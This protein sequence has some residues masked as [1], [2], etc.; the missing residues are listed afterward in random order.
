M[1]KYFLLFTI[2]CVL[3]VAHFIYSGHGIYGDGNGYWS[4]THALY[5]QH[6]LDFR[7]IYD[8]LKNFTAYNKPVPRLTWNITPTKTGALPNHW[9]IGTGILWLPS[10]V[11][12]NFL[13]N[14]CGAAISPY[15][16][17]WE[18]GPGITGIF[19][20]I[21]GCFF[22]EK[23]I[24]T[25]WSKK[26]ALYATLILLGTTNLM[27]Y[28]SIEPALSH[29]AIFFTNALLVYMWVTHRQYS[30]KIWFVWG[31]LVGLSTII[32]ITG[33]FIVIL[34]LYTLGTQ[35]VSEHHISQ[36]V[37]VSFMLFST[38]LGIAI[39]PQLVVQQIIYGSFLIQPYAVFYTEQQSISLWWLPQS[40]F[41]VERGLLFWHPSFILALL[42]LYKWQKKNKWGLLFLIYPA[43]IMLAIGFWGGALSAGFGN[44]FFIEA[45]PLLAFG[46]ASYLSG[47]SGKQVLAIFGS[48][49]LWNLLLLM[50]FFGDKARMVDQKG[51]TYLNFLT[52]QLTAPF[53]FVRRLF[54]H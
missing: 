9:L 43:A 25:V 40:L 38:G 15:N 12:L 23:A 8:N 32:R 1:K 53:I 39:F 48:L 44:R 51:L 7:H 13:F 30:K 22:V 47:T 5:F 11:L 29:S 16:I 33:I 37:L 54:I 18:L 34:P 2:C 50:Q 42:G 36:R 26:V 41:S 17:L 10:M 28:I 45:L 46:F 4:Y 14:L 49:T 24:A 31:L 21:A 27:Y 20:G 19:M 35:I 6:N 52:G 3:Y